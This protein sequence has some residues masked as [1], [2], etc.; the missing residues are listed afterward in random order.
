MAQL[1]GFEKGGVQRVQNW[2]ERGIPSQVK[3]EH[4]EIFIV[5]FLLQQRDGETTPNKKNN[6]VI[7]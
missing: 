4:P 5:P 1:L 7:V 3:V 2:I 6:K